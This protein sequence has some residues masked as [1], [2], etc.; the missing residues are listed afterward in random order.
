MHFFVIAR[1]K[2]KYQEVPKYGKFSSLVGEC[3]GGL[4]DIR[5]N[6]K[7]SFH[8]RRAVSMVPVLNLQISKQ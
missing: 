6:T 5:T 3:V 7:T 1:H 2:V 4:S 8:S